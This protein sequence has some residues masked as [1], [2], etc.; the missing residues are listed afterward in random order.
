VHAFEPNP[1]IT[2]LLRQ[3]CQRYPNI[4]IHEQAVDVAPRRGSFFLNSASS[5]AAKSFVP[6]VSGP[7]VTWTPI[8]AEYVGPDAILAL[9]P[10]VLKVDIEGIEAKFI[11]VM[12]TGAAGIPVIYIEF[13]AEDIRID[14]ER[15]LLRTHSLC[16]ARILQPRQ[17]EVMYV[18]RA[19]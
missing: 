15:L 10:D 8:D 13:H 18:R 12:G 3:N 9:N 16:Y 5:V 17:G 7:G 1:Q 11:E 19:L 6:E 14:L 2:P 4:V